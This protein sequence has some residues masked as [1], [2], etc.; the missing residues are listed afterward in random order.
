MSSKETEASPSEKNGTLMNLVDYVVAYDVDGTSQ[1]D[2]PV[3]PERV[4]RSWHIKDFA[5]C[6]H[7]N[8]KSKE[9]RKLLERVG[10]DTVVIISPK[11]VRPKKLDGIHAGSFPLVW[12]KWQERCDNQALRT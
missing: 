9:L 6:G 7:L 11:R 3:D 5:K 2:L 4:S 1:D 12:G 8:Y 10:P